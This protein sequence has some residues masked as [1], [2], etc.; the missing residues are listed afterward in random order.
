MYILTRRED[1]VIMHISETL[2]T[3]EENNYYLINNKSLAVPPQFCKGVFEEDT[4]DE[5]IIKNPEKWC[6]T[7]E[8]GFYKNPN[9]KPY[10]SDQ[11]RIEMLEE[12]INMIL[13]G[14]GE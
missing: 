8:K 2:D 1:D 13:L 6:Y 14:R 5:K 9:W 7:E 11:E 3:L 4:V 12:M 10:Y